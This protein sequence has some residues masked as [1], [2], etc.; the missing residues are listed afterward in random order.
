[1]DI[2]T[3]RFFF[4]NVLLDYST[5]REINASRNSGARV[6]TGVNSVNVTCKSCG[7]AWRATA[8][9][10]GGLVQTVGAILVTCP[11][12]ATDEGIAAKKLMG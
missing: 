2:E 7:F 3:E 12:C 1:M 9:R 5:S 4:T 11:E 8:C 6:K 10:R